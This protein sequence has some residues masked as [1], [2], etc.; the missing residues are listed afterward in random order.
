MAT[1]QNGLSIYDL[2]EG[3]FASIFCRNHN[4]KQTY[5]QK[6][7]LAAK[8]FQVQFLCRVKKSTLSQYS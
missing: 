7:I 1:R 2:S 3:S 8:Q 4:Y 6:F 5:I